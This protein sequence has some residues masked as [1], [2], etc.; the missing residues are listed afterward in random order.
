MLSCFSL[1]QSF[2]TLVDCSLLGSSVHGILQ[3]RILKWVAMSSS[4][5]S[6]PPRDQTHISHGSCTA[7]GFFTTESRGK[8]W[9]LILLPLPP[10]CLH[11]VITHSS[12]GHSPS[13]LKDFSS[14]LTA[15]LFS[16]LIITEM[17]LPLSWVLGPW[18]PPSKDL[19][20]HTVQ[21]PTS[22]VI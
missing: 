16:H 11:V 22:K 1:V 4:R 14:C 13:V 15:H 21:P 10:Q 18:L 6:S 7:G 2:A 9:K 8:V 19:V 3:A 5:G 20:P 12:P 17:I